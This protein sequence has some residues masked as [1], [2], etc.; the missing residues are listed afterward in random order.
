MLVLLGWVFAPI[1][2]SSGV[3]SILLRYFK[4]YLSTLYK[5]AYCKSN[6]VGFGDNQYIVY[7]AYVYP[8]VLYN[9]GIHD[10]ALR[11]ETPSSLL[12]RGDVD[13][14]RPHRRLGTALKPRSMC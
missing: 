1:Y 8:A 9:T 6:D 11:R 7:V 10:E 4:K 14:H 5:E 12:R 3:L 13:P 2:I